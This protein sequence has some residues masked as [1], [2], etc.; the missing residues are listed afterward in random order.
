MSAWQATSVSSQ[1]EPVLQGPHPVLQGTSIAVVWPGVPLNSSHLVL[2]AQA[3]ADSSFGSLGFTLQKEEHA[4]ELKIKLLST[5]E[6]HHSQRAAGLRQALSP[7]R[8]G[9]EQGP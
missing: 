6:A 4:D 2:W 3:Q 7:S 8:P 1:S 9:G 5:E